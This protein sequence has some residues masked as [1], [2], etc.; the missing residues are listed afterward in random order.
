VENTVLLMAQ[1]PTIAAGANTDGGILERAAAYL[2]LETAMATVDEA[3]WDPERELLRPFGLSALPEHLV[4]AKVQNTRR[5]R[6]LLKDP[7]A[8][9]KSRRRDAVGPEGRVEDLVH[10]C[11]PTGPFGRDEARLV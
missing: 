10:S 4:R 3:P 1:I 11:E 5:Q 9:S 7:A 2:P 6:A 8:G